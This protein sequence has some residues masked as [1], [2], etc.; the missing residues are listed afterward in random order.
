MYM[1]KRRR[2]YLSGLPAW[3]CAYIGILYVLYVL[4]YTITLS[5]VPEV[6]TI[7][8]LPDGKVSVQPGTSIH[9]VRK[10]LSTVGGCDPPSSSSCQPTRLLGTYLAASSHLLPS[11]ASSRVKPPRYLGTYLGLWKTIGKHRVWASRNQLSNESPSIT[12]LIV[13][14]VTGNNDSN[15]PSK[16][17]PS[18]LGVR[19][20]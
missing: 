19:N 11:P 17:Y 3:P 7:T 1:S 6:V 16:A 13:T 18:F 5:S 2:R 14:R 4:R 10:Y 9:Q 20:R 12:T 15:L 8:K